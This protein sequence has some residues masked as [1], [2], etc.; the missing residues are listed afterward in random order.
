MITTSN[1]EKISAFKR[2]KSNVPFS[3]SLNNWIDRQFKKLPFSVVFCDFEPY[4]SFPD[5]VEQF[6]LSGQKVLKIS[7]LHSEKTIFGNPET[8]WK[9]RAIHDYFHIDRNLDFSLQDE[10]MV[11]YLQM[12]YA[13]KELNGFDLQLLNIETAGQIVYYSTFGEFPADQRAFTIAELEK[14]YPKV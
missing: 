5:M 10:L 8:N 2:Y 3:Q 12:Q 6:N 11:N 14:F 13:S 1:Q 9:F 7:T 4:T